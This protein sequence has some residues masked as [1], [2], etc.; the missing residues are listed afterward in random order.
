MA[1]HSSILAW[2]ISWA[3]KPGRSQN[4]T[5]LSN[6]HKHVHA[7]THTHTQTHA[8]THRAGASRRQQSA[9]YRYLSWLAE[10]LK[11]FLDPSGDW[12][13]RSGDTER[14]KRP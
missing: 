14:E 5:L 2:R 10:Q 4:Q 7:W 1:T 12:K 8:R 6:T 9:D 13:A 11:V 3:E